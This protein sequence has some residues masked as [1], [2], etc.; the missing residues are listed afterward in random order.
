[1]DKEVSRLLICDYVLHMSLSS[2]LERT[3]R[4]RR[5]LLDSVGLAIV[6][7]WGSGPGE[8]VIETRVKV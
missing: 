6:K 1:M 5:A 4:Q 2:G 8:S 7:I 3:E